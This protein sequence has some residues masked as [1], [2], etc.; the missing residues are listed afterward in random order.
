M[1]EERVKQ[2]FETFEKK[3]TRMDKQLLNS[4]SWYKKAEN[5]LI[6]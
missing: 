3:Q 6:C 2:G 5:E 4:N 1:G